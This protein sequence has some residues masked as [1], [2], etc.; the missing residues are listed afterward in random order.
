VAAGIGRILDDRIQPPYLGLR[1]LA[2]RHPVARI[3]DT[4]LLY[5]FPDGASP[6]G[7]VTCGWRDLAAG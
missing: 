3:G 7:S 6:S 2:C 4:I 1:W 5:H